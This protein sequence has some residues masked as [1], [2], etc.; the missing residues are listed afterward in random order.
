[1]A[2]PSRSQRYFE[3]WQRIL[4]KPFDELLAT[5]VQDSEQM[6]AMRQCTPF[7]GVLTPRER[8][9]IYDAFAA[10]TRDSGSGGDCERS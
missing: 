7:A 2:E 3:Q 9:S 5:I 4:A 6:T 1:M 8:W 10:G